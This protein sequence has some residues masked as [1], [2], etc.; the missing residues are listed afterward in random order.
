MNTFS[1][2][3]VSPVPTAFVVKFTLP[4]ISCLAAQDSCEKRRDRIDDVLA[5]CTSKDLLYGKEAL[6]N[7]ESERIFYKF[8]HLSPTQCAQ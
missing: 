8:S 6:N 2:R 5:H 3:I 7:E 4:L 1:T